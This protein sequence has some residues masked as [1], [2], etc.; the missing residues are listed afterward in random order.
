M[1]TLV[2]LMGAIVGFGWFGWFFDVLV[3]GFGV[4]LA[5]F[6]V[7]LVH[8]PPLFLVYGVYFGQIFTA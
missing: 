3:G 7:F 2:W 1:L 6:A 5:C 8:K 4:D